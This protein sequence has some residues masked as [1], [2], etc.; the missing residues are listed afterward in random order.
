MAD[1]S[2]AGLVTRLAHYAV[3]GTVGNLIVKGASRA[4]PALRPHVRGLVVSS[5]AQGIVLTRKLEGAAE[6][7]RLKAGDLFADARAQLG[8]TAAPPTTPPDTSGAAHVHEH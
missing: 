8:E 2:S 5:I 7:T 3:A 1:P 6:D 4:T